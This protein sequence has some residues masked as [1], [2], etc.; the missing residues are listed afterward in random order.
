MKIKAEL[1][2][3]ASALETVSRVAPPVSGNINLELKDAKLTISSV[4]EVSWCSLIVPAEVTGKGELSVPIQALKDAIKGRQS[5]ELSHENA[6]LVVRS[7]KYKAEL[8]TVD[9]IPRDIQDPEETKEWKITAEQAGWLRKA[10]KEVQL[11]PTAILSSWMPIGVKLTKS[12]AF[13]ACYDTQHMSWASTKEVTGDF[14]CVLPIETLVNLV[15]VFHKS[16][17][18]IEQGRSNLL[19]RNKLS[20]VQVSLPVTDELPSISDVQGKIKEASKASG[21]DFAFKK[22]DFLVFLDNARAVLGKERAEI[23]IAG[24]GKAVELQIKT[25]NGQV[26]NIVPGSGKGKFLVDFE[27]MLELVTKAPEE[28]QLKVVDSA[29][30]SSK[31]GASSVIVALNQS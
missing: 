25:G 20:K 4:A 7:G 29:F 13:V 16:N 2:A 3:L 1:D 22:T 14:E 21:T 11:K 8:A 10:L 23:S 17:F 26:N 24:N 30:L 15:E 28:V 6:V 9:V 18:I 12:G 19:A 27:Y 31:L 5:L